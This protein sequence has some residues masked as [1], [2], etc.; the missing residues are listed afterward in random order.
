MEL[1]LSGALLELA[2]VLDGI[3]FHELL[4]LPKD[5]MINLGRND[6]EKSLLA[7]LYTRLNADVYCGY[8]F[9]FQHRDRYGMPDI[10]RDR[11]GMPDVGRDRYGMP[12]VGRYNV[13]DFSSVPGF[14]P[15]PGM[16]NFCPGAPIMRFP[17]G[18]PVDSNPYAAHSVGRGVPF[19]SNPYAAP[20]FSH[21][22]MPDHYL[23]DNSPPVDV[24]LDG[25]IHGSG[26][27]PENVA[28]I[29]EKMPSVISLQV[30]GNINRLNLQNNHLTPGDL[31]HI[32]EAV[33]NARI[34]VM[35]LRN[36]EFGSMTLDNECY[37]NLRYIH[38][39][40]EW[41]IMDKD[42]QEF[43]KKA[44]AEFVDHGG[45][46]PMVTVDGQKVPYNP[47]DRIITCT[48]EEII[49]GAA[50]P[51]IAQH[52]KYFMLYP[53]ET[54]T[55]LKT[56][57]DTIEV[58]GRAKNKPSAMEFVSTADHPGMSI[59]A[60]V[61]SNNDDN[62]PVVREEHIPVV[63]EEHIP[64]VKEEHIPNV[65]TDDNNDND[66]SDDYLFANPE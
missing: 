29:P 12:D 2:S 21:H 24:N 4:A 47:F 17:R 44:A 43:L 50:V 60:V 23:G 40:V 66:N 18:V 15:G 51:N 45:S 20:K 65:K 33:R 64:N 19:D 59:M 16:P 63:G 54:V 1:M 55:T 49:K 22:G 39:N 5:M 10:E 31:D 34:K 36:N 56:V 38:A 13:P 6:R 8:P 3:K 9:A 26:K 61:P 53:G 28:N 7:V 62:L 37:N 52:N 11:Y 25:E 42:V 35:D 41:I 57:N 48:F 27:W 46:I 14:C 32:V 58:S 30:N